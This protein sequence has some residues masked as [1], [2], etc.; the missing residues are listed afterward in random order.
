MDSNRDHLC[1]SSKQKLGYL[2]FLVVFI[3]FLDI[4]ALFRQLIVSSVISVI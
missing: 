1:K 2:T 3:L 4:N